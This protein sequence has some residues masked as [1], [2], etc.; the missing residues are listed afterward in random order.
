M[1]VEFWI[2][3][4]AIVPNKN[5]ALKE[6]AGGVLKKGDDN[7]QILKPSKGFFFRNS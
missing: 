3:N 1:P 2:N 4:T 7:N 6:K 5:Y